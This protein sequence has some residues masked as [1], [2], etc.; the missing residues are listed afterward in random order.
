MKTLL[1]KSICLLPGLIATLLIGCGT[2]DTIDSPDSSE[3]NW[4][5]IL[6]ASRGTALFSPRPVV[7][8]SVDGKA[9]SAMANSVRVSPG[10]HVLV[11][12]CYQSLFARNTHELTVSVEA[13]E[14]YSLS[15][16]IVP[17]KISDGSEDCEARLSK[18]GSE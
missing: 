15:S 7:I 5:L 1:Q 10:I 3:A 2:T 13:G 14:T 18:S 4:A 9:V 17:N 11:V 16:Q 12:T 6:G 8:K